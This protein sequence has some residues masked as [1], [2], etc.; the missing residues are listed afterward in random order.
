MC[1]VW[2]VLHTVRRGLWGH[3]PIMVSRIAQE[4]EEAEVNDTNVV[5]G[6]GPAAGPAVRYSV[7]AMGRRSRDYAG[8]V[9]AKVPLRTGAGGSG[10]GST[11]PDSTGPVAAPREARRDEGKSTQPWDVLQRLVAAR[12]AHAGRAV[13][14]II[15]V[16]G[17]TGGFAE[18]G[19]NVTVVDRSPDALAAAQRRAAE[20]QVRLAA[21]QGDADGL[22]HLVGDA[23]ADLVICHSV[24][25][26]VEDPV[27]AMAAIASVLRPGGSVSV[28]AGN[29]VAAALHGALSGRYDQAREILAGITGTAGSI[30]V[31]GRRR[32]TLAGLEALIEGA[33]LRTGAAYGVRVFA[34]L[35]S[36]A[37][38][39]PG[40]VDALRA[41]EDEAAAYPALRDIAAKLHVL[42]ER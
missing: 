39:D 22:D 17:G 31:D 9:A 20:R 18:L 37:D 11:A 8:T 6:S 4:R 27:A 36:S 12:A 15:D 40:S 1:V 23:A 29:A 21:V 25:D 10:P 24:L 7:E 41:L 28:I 19:H 42:A 5:P 38:P 2:Q 32:F 16:G 33:G 3:L 14:D 26:Y 34:S 13:L 35:L 30:T